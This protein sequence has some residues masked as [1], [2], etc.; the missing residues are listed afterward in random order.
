[1]DYYGKS[2]PLLLVSLIS[3]TISRIHRWPLLCQ[4]Q[5]LITIHI[6]TCYPVLIQ[7]YIHI[8]TANN[9]RCVISQSANNRHPN[10]FINILD[11]MPTNHWHLDIMAICQIQHHSVCYWTLSLT[12]CVSN[13][14]GCDQY[15]GISIH[16]QQWHQTSILIHIQLKLDNLHFFIHCNRTHYALLFVLVFPQ[17]HAHLQHIFRYFKSHIFAKNINRRTKRSFVISSYTFPYALA[18]KYSDERLTNL[19]RIPVPLILVNLTAIRFED[20]IHRQQNIQRHV[21]CSLTSIFS[22]GHWI[23]HIRSIYSKFVQSQCINLWHNLCFYRRI[24]KLHCHL[25]IIPIQIWE[26]GIVWW[27]CRVDICFNDCANHQCVWFFVFAG[28]AIPILSVF[29]PIFMV[30]G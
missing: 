12:Q 8:Y 13:S 14:L 25:P 22:M 30:F 23:C 9:S 24:W 20:P 11:S 28:R 1:M 4:L 3:N 5:Q 26:N 19:W 16:P 27:C 2:L 10:Q 7:I 21:F 18:S 15:D 6:V 29:Y 17:N